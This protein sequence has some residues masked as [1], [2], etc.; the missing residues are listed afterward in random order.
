LSDD[1][2]LA[3]IAALSADL[4]DEIVKTQTDIIDRIDRHQAIDLLAQ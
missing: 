2:V 3:A 1:R 4:R